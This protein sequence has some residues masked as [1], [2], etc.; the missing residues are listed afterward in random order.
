MKKQVEEE[1]L[2]REQLFRNI[3]QIVKEQV[4]NAVNQNTSGVFSRMWG[5]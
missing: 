2:M 1:R 3:D 5:R 4:Q